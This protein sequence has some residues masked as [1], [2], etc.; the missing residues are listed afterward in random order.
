M[1]YTI[2]CLYWA[3]RKEYRRIGICANVAISGPSNLL[4]LMQ[5]MNKPL[6]R[7][8]VHLADLDTSGGHI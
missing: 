5:E 6:G 4:D 1:A 2:K 7:N 8:A 3:T